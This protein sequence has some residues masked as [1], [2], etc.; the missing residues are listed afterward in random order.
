MDELNQNSPLERR[1]LPVIFIKEMRFESKNVRLEY[2]PPREIPPVIP[3]GT[4]MWWSIDDVFER[5]INP[6]YALFATAENVEA[7][8]DVNFSVSSS[9][10]ESDQVGVEEEDSYNDPEL[11]KLLQEARFEAQGPVSRQDILE[12]LRTKLNLFVP[13]EK[14]V[15]LSQT[16]SRTGEHEVPLKINNRH[17]ESLRVVIS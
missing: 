14:H 17:R 9:E 7:Y 3:A 16:L 5:V 12:F 1:E 13:S 11:K 15:M 8:S 10:V 6:G 4:L 2:Y